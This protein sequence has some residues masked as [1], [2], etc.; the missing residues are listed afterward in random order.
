MRSKWPRSGFT[1][2][3]SM[4]TVL[5]VMLVFG[6]VS[7]LLLGSYQVMRVQRQRTEAAEAA[8]LALTRIINELREAARLEV[9]ASPPS[10][11]LWKVNAAREAERVTA[12][13]RLQ[14]MV[15]VRYSLDAESNLLRDVEDLTSGTTA[16]HLVANNIAGLT[17]STTPDS[18]NVIVTLNVQVN[19][20]LR[21]ITSEVAPL[22][23]LPRP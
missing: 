10:V 22:A 19:G 20:V 3:E 5:L 4:I 23:T 7:D 15:R 9:V 6:L 1:L 8:Q 21:P 13:N 17:V 11:T 16:Q 14:H 18:D 2:L 12:P